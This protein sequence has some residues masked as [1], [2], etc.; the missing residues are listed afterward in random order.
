MLFFS[1][2]VSCISKIFF[3]VLYLPTSVFQLLTVFSFVPLIVVPHKNFDL[4]FV[5]QA[6]SN[7]FFILPEL[8]LAFLKL[9]FSFISSKTSFSRSSQIFFY[10]S[11]SSSLRISHSFS[12]IF[13]YCF[14]FSSN[15]RFFSCFQQ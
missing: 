4:N 2:I 9:F 6:L 11:S 8:V 3:I 10:F 1:R 14:S 15:R 13:G 12:R 7:S 5:F